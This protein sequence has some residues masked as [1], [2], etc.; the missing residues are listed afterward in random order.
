MISGGGGGVHSAEEVE[1]EGGVVR[2]GAGLDHGVA[3]IL[4]GA[5]GSVTDEEEERVV[6]GEGV[7]EVVVA[8]DPSEEV[9]GGEG[10]GVEVE[11]GAEEGRG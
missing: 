7:G 10:V 11:E 2:G 3:D 9:E 6:G 8:A 4:G 1:E 5:E